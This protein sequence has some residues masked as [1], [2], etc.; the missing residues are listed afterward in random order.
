MSTRRKAVT[1]RDVAKKAGVGVSTVSYVL[2]GNDNHV[3]PATREQILAAVRE[4]NYRPNAIA[5]SMVRRAT[6]TIGLIITE[7][8]NPLFVP[9]AEGVEAV[10][11]AES[12]HIILV[13]AKDVEDE[14]SAIETLRAQQVDGLIFMSLSVHYESDHLKQLT[15][16]GVPFVLINRDL[17]D[18]EIN[19]IKLDDRGAAYT[20]TQHLIDLGHKRI[21]TIAGPRDARR[22]AEYR[23]QGW[24]EAL[25]ANG[26]ESVSNWIV[27][28][29]YTYDAGYEAAQEL[30]NQL[31]GETNGPTAVFIANEA[32][33][34]S[35][36]KVFHQAGIRVPD[37]LAIVTI[38]DPPFAYTIPAL[39]TMALPVV[40]AGRIGATIVV[41]WLRNG[42]PPQP[43]Y[44]NLGFTF[45]IRE[46]CGA[47][48]RALP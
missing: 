2:N 11:K 45:N 38:G 19:Q 27:S 3:G 29:P 14:I 16:E 41:D 18:P 15:A 48:R 5:R 39:T 33:A 28:A 44:I 47:T 12:Y 26:L 46:S 4:L 43:Q 6:A 30:L 8:N 23:H 1:I 13:Q 21:A 42:K 36:L 20:V 35:A 10:L 7:L 37:D 22:S 24:L 25:T 17:D 32:L 31:A 9:V 40:E 34:V